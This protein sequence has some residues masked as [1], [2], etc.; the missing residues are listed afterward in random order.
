MGAKAGPNCGEG[1][2]EAVR[3]GNRMRGLFWAPSA[4]FRSPR[5]PK[6]LPISARAYLEAMTVHFPFQNTYAALP[7]NFFARVAPTPV[8]APA[9]DQAEPA[10]GGPSR[11]RSGPARQPGRRRNPRRQPH[12]RRRRP[13]RDGLC[14]PPVRAFRAAARRRPR[15]PA[16]RSHRPRRRAP[17]HP[18][19]GLR[20]DAVFAP[21][22]R[23]RRARAGA[24]RI[25]RQRGDGRARHPDHAL[26]CRRHDRR[27]R[28]ARDACCPAP[29]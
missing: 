9:A 18:A 25:H 7:A 4:T 24:A 19:Q 13:D 1:L 14:R 15:H 20:P 17:R 8:A 16:R 22:R 5:R 26:A 6:P 27:E 12:A 23:P 29:C 21:G 28:D 11:P 3:R 2:P 10:A